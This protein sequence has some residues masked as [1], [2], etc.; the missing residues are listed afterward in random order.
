MTHDLKT[1]K[2]DADPVANCM[3]QVEPFDVLSTRFQV[4]RHF[5]RATHNACS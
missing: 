4:V 3:K 2:R 1:N 5:Y